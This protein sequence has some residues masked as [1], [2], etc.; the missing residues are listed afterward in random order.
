MGVK[1]GDG[2]NILDGYRV[3]FNIEHENMVKDPS[4]YTFITAIICLVF[5]SLL[6]D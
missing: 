4:N 1:E 6:H 2:R 3:H 5:S